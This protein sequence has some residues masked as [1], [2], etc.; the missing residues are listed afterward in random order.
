[1]DSEKAQPTASDSSRL[2]SDSLPRVFLPVTPRKSGNAWAQRLELEKQ[3]K[4][5]QQQNQSIPSTSDNKIAAPVFSDSDAAA[6]A[7]K[8]SGMHDKLLAVNTIP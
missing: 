1:M 5:K 2:F 8:A 7:V 6:L 4:Q 3:Q